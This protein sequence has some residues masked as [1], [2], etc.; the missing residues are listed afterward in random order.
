MNIREYYEKDGEKLPGKGESS[1]PLSQI[2]G[3][4]Y[5][6]EI[7]SGYCSL[8]GAGTKLERIRV[9]KR[10]QSREVTEQLAKALTR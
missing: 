3:V 10:A 6:S 8:L 7:M 5:E 1:V 4:Q 2:S 9:P